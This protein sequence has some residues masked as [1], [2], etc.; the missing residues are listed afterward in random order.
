MCKHII[1]IHILHFTST[2]YCSEAKRCKLAEKLENSKDWE[3]Y[4]HVSTFTKFI[5]QVGPLLDQIKSSQVILFI[6][7][8]L[9]KTNPFAMAPCH[10][11]LDIIDLFGYNCEILVSI[12]RNKYRVL[13]AYSTHAAI[14]VN[15]VQ[16]EKGR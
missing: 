7:P 3:L 13:D 1:V 11:G 6:P 15:H 2:K 4:P 9:P 12:L 14:P 16:I 8:I 10:Q 5:I